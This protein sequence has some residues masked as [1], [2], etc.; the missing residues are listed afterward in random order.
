MQREKTSIVGI[1]LGNPDVREWLKTR[2][3]P[4]PKLG[5]NASQ[6]VGENPYF[7]R[8]WILAFHES[9]DNFGKGDT[10]IYIFATSTLNGRPYYPLIDPNIDLAKT[11]ASLFWKDDWILPLPNLPVDFEQIQPFDRQFHFSNEA[12]RQYLSEHPGPGNQFLD[13]LPNETPAT[14][15]E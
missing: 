8:E 5:R 4:F 6:K 14:Q 15:P 12:I 1:H 13:K 9:L 10:P 11:K 2:P 7:L 3:N